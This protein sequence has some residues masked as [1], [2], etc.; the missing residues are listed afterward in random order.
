M[1]KKSMMTLQPAELQKL[2]SVEERTDRR[3]IFLHKVQCNAMQCAYLTTDFEG[4]LVEDLKIQC[5]C[6]FHG[7]RAFSKTIPRTYM[8]V[9]MRNLTASK[10]S[11]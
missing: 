7:T 5:N 9:V 1:E 8:E 3:L 4:S 6:F 10:K 11:R 2:N